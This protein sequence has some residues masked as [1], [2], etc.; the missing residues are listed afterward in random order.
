MKQKF[1]QA[2]YEPKKLIFIL[3]ENAF[4]RWALRAK[5]AAH[6]AKGLSRSVEYVVTNDG[7]CVAAECAAALGMES[8]DIKD[9]QINASSSYNEGSV[10]VQNARLNRELNGGAWCPERQISKDVLEYLEVY[11][12]TL[13]V[14]SAVATQGRF[15]NGQGREY[16]EDYALEYWR[17]GL[18]HWKRFSDRREEQ[19]KRAHRNGKI[20]LAVTL[21][22]SYFLRNPNLHQRR[23]HIYNFPIAEGGRNMNPCE[24]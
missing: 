22:Y 6:F 7:E 14:I 5:T 19:A 12:P 18:S 4:L 3:H 9:H 20:S 24:K 11:L 23:M 17:P 1:I 10:G 2:I 15:G 16:T 21:K 8:G 13:H